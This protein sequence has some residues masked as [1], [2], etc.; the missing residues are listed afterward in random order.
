VQVQDGSIASYSSNGPT[1][2]GR[3]KPDIVAPTGVRSLAMEMVA[4]TA[5][6][7]DGT[8]A[9]APHAAGFAALLRQLRPDVSVSDLHKLLKTSV[10]PLG[11]PIPNLTYGYGHLD[12][13]RVAIPRPDAV[14]QPPEGAP[15]VPVNTID[16]L[17]DEII[18]G[19][20]ASKRP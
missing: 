9:A 15:A 13:R 4:G 6:V 16:D 14:V 8:S 20:K 3:L 17:L 19:Q 10:R 12:A 2:D 11:S 1:D 7:F 5:A 18:E